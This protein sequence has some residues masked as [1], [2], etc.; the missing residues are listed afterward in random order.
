MTRLFTVAAII[1]L[2]SACAT[3]LKPINV[4]AIT[5]EIRVNQR[6]LVPC[7]PLAKLP[8][9]AKFEDILPNIRSIA[10]TYHSCSANNDALILIINEMANAKDSKRVTLDGNS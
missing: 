10:E 2:L 6:L 8:E 4:S 3:P 9:N 1:M 7:A 5:S